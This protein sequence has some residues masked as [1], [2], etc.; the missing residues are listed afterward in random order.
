MKTFPLDPIEKASRDELQALQL[1]RMKAQ[2]WGGQQ[3]HC[4]DEWRIFEPPAD[5]HRPHNTRRCPTRRPS[6]FGSS[7]LRGLP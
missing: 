5:G 6:S 4:P 1:I 2:L 7:A 3:W